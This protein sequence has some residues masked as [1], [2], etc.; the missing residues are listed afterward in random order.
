MFLVGV[1]VNSA[2]TQHA[3]HPDLGTPEDVDTEHAGA[4][5]NLLSRIACPCGALE[6]AVSLPNQA[7]VSPRR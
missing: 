1:G 4:P 3:P 7:S 5:A 6:L 2:P